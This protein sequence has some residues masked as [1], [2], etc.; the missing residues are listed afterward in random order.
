M[1]SVG[2]VRSVGKPPTSLTAPTSL[3]VLLALVIPAPL[4]AQPERVSIRTAPVPGLTSRMSITQELQFDISAAALPAPMAMQGTVLL[5][6]TQ[7]TGS[8]DSLGVISAE[9]TYDTMA[10]NMSMNGV[11]MPQSTS[12]TGKA[13]V[14]KF[15]SAGTLLGVEVPADLE[16][17]AGN[18][19]QILASTLGNLPRNP[20]GVGDST[21]VPL[22]TPLPFNAFGTS[23]AEAPVLEGT[24][25][26]R[27]T[28]LIREGS[29]PILTLDQVVAGTMKRPVEMPGLGT[30]Q[31]DL[32]MEG[33]GT[34]VVNAS[35]GL[36]RSGR[37]EARI[38]MNLDLGAGGIMTMTGTVRTTTSGT[39]VP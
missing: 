16:P 24:V 5:R 30:A 19:R 26:Y 35:N 36:V 3:T 1:S 20:I 18:I 8:P 15:D 14:V 29:D 27:A 17:L 21:T 32:R 31:V 6:F 12:L 22:R 4:H 33:T 37:N 7:R 39:L 11:A 25:T 34:L 23:G 13:M 2:S 9:L 10:V 38:T 28:R